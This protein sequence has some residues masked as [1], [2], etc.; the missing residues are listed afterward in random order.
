MSSQLETHSRIYIRQSA[1]GVIVS[2]M[3][4]ACPLPPQGRSRRRCFCRCIRGGSLQCRDIAQ[5]APS[6]PP[7]PTPT[8]VAAS[9]RPPSP[10][11]SPKPSSTAVQRVNADHKK[12][13]P[14]NFGE[15]IG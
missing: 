7:T 1:L 3:R 13:D 12:F 6:A 11:P 8:Q 5:T 4:R 2:E 15:P 14:K 9:A 10:T